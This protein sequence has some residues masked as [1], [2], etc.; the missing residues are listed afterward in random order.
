VAAGGLPANRQRPA[1]AAA[2]PMLVKA[3]RPHREAVR[4]VAQPPAADGGPSAIRL[5]AGPAAAKR[6]VREPAVKPLAPGRAGARMPRGAGKPRT[7]IPGVRG[8]G[9]AIL[10]AVPGAN[11]P[12]VPAMRL[13]APAVGARL[14]RPK[15]RRVAVAE[16]GPHAEARAAATVERRAA[17]IPAGAARLAQRAEVAQIA[18]AHRLGWNRREAKRPAARPE[19][20]NRPGAPL[21]REANRLRGPNRPGPNLPALA[22]EAMMTWRARAPA[23]PFPQAAGLSAAGRAR[24]GRPARLIWAKPAAAGALDRP[25]ADRA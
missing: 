9:S 24:D 7:P 6:L 21:R 13:K 23:R 10:G 17:S 22:G 2:T 18:A 15:A 12:S 4:P 14:V 5:A 25:A 19:A 1:P 3:V 20:L 8:A 16:P 11:P